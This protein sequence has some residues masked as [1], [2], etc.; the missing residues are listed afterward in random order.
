MH[1][2]GQEHRK[3]ISDYQVCTHRFENHL[4]GCKI[5]IIV[6]GLKIMI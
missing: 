6:L 2:G 5:V 4:G 1:L 3:C